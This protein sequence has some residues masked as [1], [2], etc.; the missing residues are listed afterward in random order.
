MPV[1]VIGRRIID[2]PRHIGAHS[3]S[4]HQ[5]RNE[6]RIGPLFL[7]FFSDDRMVILQ[8]IGHHGVARNRIYTASLE[9]PV[10]SRIVIALMVASSTRFDNVQC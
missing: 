7:H 9:L 4:A 8:L 5:P 6:H 10:S 2:A 1:T 3:L